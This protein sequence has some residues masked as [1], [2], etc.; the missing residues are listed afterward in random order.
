MLA[1][2]RAYLVAESTYTGTQIQHK[3]ITPPSDATDLQRQGRGCTLSECPLCFRIL[4]L[5]TGTASRG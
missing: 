2:H 5:F 3:Q 1:L 4:A